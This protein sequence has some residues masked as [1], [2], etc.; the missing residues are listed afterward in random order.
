MANRNPQSSQMADESMV[1][2]LAAQV[3]CIWPQERLLFE[4]YGSPKKILDVGCGTGVFTALL[5]KRYPEA[6]VVGIEL[7]PSHVIRAKRA[8]A[9][10]GN[11]VCIEEGDAFNI[12]YPSS[13]FELV[14]CRHLLQAIPEPEKVVAQCQRVTTPKGWLHLLIEDY[15][16]IHIEGP[17]YFDR[18]W[19]EGALRFGAELGCDLRIGRRGMEL[20]EGCEHKRLD[21]ITVDTERVERSDFADVFTAWRDGYTEGLA[22]YLGGKERVKKIWDEMIRAINTGYALWQ[23][24]VASGRKTLGPLED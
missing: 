1:R 15:T 21:Y 9:A 13:S 14:V 4:R 8:C 10:F 3:R 2:T 5:A 20:L 19:I 11:R 23:V 24:P 17:E 18:F 6:Q 7:D 12:Q 22:P 16:M